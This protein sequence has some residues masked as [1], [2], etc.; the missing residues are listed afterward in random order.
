MA[1]IEKPVM[2]WAGGARNTSTTGCVLLPGART[3]RRT[4]KGWSFATGQFR[5]SLYIESYIL[6]MYNR[7][8]FITPPASTKG[9]T[10][11]FRFS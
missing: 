9:P 5:L 7:F 10:M 2:A 8:F 1:V 11:Y 4:E 6:F 3:E